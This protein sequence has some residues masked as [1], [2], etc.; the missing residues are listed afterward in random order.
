[1]KN[2]NQ[3]LNRIGIQSYNTIKTVNRM[4]T[5]NNYFGITDKSSSHLDILLNNDIEVFI[6]P[7]HI[8]NNRFDNEIARAVYFRIKSF[9]TT[10]NTKYVLPIKRKEGIRF[11]SPLK[12]A[13]EYH[14]GYSFK[15]KGKGVG[16]I[17]AKTIFDSLSKNGFIQQGITITNEAHNVLLLV[18]GIGQDNMSDILANV[19]RDLFAEYTSQQ[20]QKYGIKTSL[21]SIKFYNDTTQK[22]ETKEVQLPS[23]KGQKII[24]IP[25]FLASKTLVYPNRYNWLVSREYISPDILNGKIDTTDRNKF[26]IELKDGSEKCITKEINKCF[27]KKKGKLIEFETEYNGSLDRFKEHVKET[28]LPVSNEELSNLQNKAS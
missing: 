26:V 23:Y 18:E 5:F 1:M 7:Y 28:Y 20:C 3:P 14:L 8:A 21:F 4:N 9:F 22:W 10:L 11:L 27:K 19:C 13:N 2:N 12:E 16:S 25:Q 6:D 24:L 15:N 17:K